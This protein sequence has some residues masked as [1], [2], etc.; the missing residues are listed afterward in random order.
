MPRAAIPAMDQRAMVHRPLLA[1]ELHLRLLRMVEVTVVLTRA[2]RMG[3]ADKA[4][5][6]RTPHRTPRR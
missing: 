3:T 2:H 4:R 6:L 1:M 5:M